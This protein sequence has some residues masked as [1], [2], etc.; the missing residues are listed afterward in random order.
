LTPH[1]AACSI[2]VRKRSIRTRACATPVIKGNAR[3][4]RALA[5]DIAAAKLICAPK[6]EWEPQLLAL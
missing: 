3:H 6:A 1:R 2:L 5:R 4:A